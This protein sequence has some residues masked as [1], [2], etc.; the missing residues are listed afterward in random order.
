MEQF[1]FILKNSY[2]IISYTGVSEQLRIWKFSENCK[3]ELKIGDRDSTGTKVLKY[4][5]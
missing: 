5:T 2:F 3:A 1:S 4:V